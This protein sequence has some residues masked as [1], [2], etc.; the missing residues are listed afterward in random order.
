[1]RSWSMFWRS[2]SMPTR[3]ASSRAA[4]P[5]PVDR[6]TVGAIVAGRS[7]DHG[8]PQRQVDRE[9]V[10]ATAQHVAFVDQRRD[11][12]RE[13]GPLDRHHAGQTRMHRQREHVAAQRRQRTGRGIDR[14]EIDQQ[15]AC[16]TE[17]SGGRR[18]DEDQ[19]AGRSVRIRPDAPRGEFE[20]QPGEVA[21]EDLR[22]PVFRPGAVFEL[23]PQSI[24][25]TRLGSAG[26]TRPLLG[27]CSARGHRGQPC[28]PGPWIEPRLAGKTGIDHDA[29][30]VDGQRGLGDVGAQH[31]ASAARRRRLQCTIL[32]VL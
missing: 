19:V 18:V 23:A 14:M 13:R 21:L 25:G 11:D 12:A 16:L 7:G 28:H 4:V 8:D 1:M 30:P 31:H 20:H 27:R 29:D 22:G 15:V 9:L 32:F 2:K 17:R 24:R 3:R 10:G 6:T 26:S 5:Q